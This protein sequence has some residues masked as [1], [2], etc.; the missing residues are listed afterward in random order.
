MPNICQEGQMDPEELNSWKTQEV[1]DSQ[2][3]CC[4]DFPSLLGTLE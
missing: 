4:S 1:K 2:H 3:F